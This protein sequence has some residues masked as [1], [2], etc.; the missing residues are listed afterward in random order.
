M[1]PPITKPIVIFRHI[2]HEGPGCLGDFL[3]AQNI[4]W[5]LIKIDE[6]E[7]LP[8]SILA[9]RGMVLMGGPMSANGDLPWIPPLLDLVREAHANDI[10]LLGHC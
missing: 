2:A 8:S 4:P 10:P 7:P 3:N 1:K 9:Y 6:G 5:Q